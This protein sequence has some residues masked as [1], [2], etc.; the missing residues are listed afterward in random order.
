[1]LIEKISESLGIPI[2]Y[3]ES[4]GRRASHLYKVYSIPKKSGGLRIIHHPARELKAVQRWLLWNVL[5]KLPVHR[6]AVGYR[7]GV[8]I[9]KNAELHKRSRYLLRLDFKDFFPSIHSSDIQRYIDSNYTHFEKWT[10]IDRDIF[11]KIV[12]R[13]K[14]L[15]IGAPTSPC[16]SNILCYLLD[17]NISEITKEKQIKYTRYADDMYFSATKPN[18]LSDIEG[19]VTGIIGTIQYPSGMQLNK[20]KTYNVSMKGR[21]IVTGLVL[22]SDG[23]VSIGRER[24]RLIRSLVYK[25]DELS[26]KDKQY[27]AGLLS[28]TKS[29]EPD[30][31]N[32]LALKYG[33]DKVRSASR[34]P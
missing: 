21:R 18:L 28:Y 32:R 16:L 19:I 31:V 20:E 1:M 26:E 22:T 25:Y 5:E 9:L 30:F 2:E 3:I 12:C 34:T 10:N 8:N 15:T 33:A 27:L 11:C 7:K 13:N 6:S 23:N 4:I 24:K 17:E 29:I 14:R